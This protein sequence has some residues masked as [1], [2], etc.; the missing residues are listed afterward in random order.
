M[1]TGIQANGTDL[2]SVFEA[3]TTTK[4]ADVNIDSNGSVDLSNRFEDIASGSA[5]AATGIQSG[6]ADLDT[7][8]AGIGTVGSSPTVSAQANGDVNSI[9]VGSECYVGCRFDNTGQEQEQIAFS[10]AWGS[11]L[12]TWLTA[13][14]AAD[15]WVV[16]TRTAGAT[17]WDTHTSG[18]RYNL[19]TSRGFSL[20]STSGTRSITGYF[21]FYD[22]A[23]GGTLLDTSPT[24]LW[25]ATFTAGGMCTIC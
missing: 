9:S 19:A 8:F 16:F 21:R 14:S 23:T 15:V 12:N 25:S 2:D 3:R 20:S 24:V 17:N 6:G 22:A 10:G 5:A 7:K 13:G 4:I 18:T 11:D 1:V